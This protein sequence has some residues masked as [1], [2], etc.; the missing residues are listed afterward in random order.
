MAFSYRNSNGYTTSGL[1]TINGS[2][3]PGLGQPIDYFNMGAL[4]FNPGQPQT[5][6]PGAVWQGQG[7]GYGSTVRPEDRMTG[8]FRAPPGSDVSTT[9]LSFGPN[10]S[11]TAFYNDVLTGKQLPFD[12]TTKD[13][14]LSDASDMTAAAE[15]AQRQQMVNAAAAGGASATDPSLRGSENEAAAAR[16]AGNVRAKQGI[17][18]QANKANF[19]AKS[20]AAAHMMDYDLQQQAFKNNWAKTALGFLPMG[21]GGGG[22]SGGQLGGRGKAQNQGFLGFGSDPETNLAEW[23]QNNPNMSRRA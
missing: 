10:A 7:G 22:G 15:S 20:D 13:S 5:G 21:G 23:Q 18:I 11:A 14:M 16:Q 6:G 4:G 1:D 17:D 8:G 19:G 2:A 12:Q 9:S 3:Y